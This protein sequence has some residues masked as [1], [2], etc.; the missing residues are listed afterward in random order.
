MELANDAV[1]DG[2]MCTKLKA[3]VPPV[4]A[5]QASTSTYKSRQKL[6]SLSAAQVLQDDIREA[7][8]TVQVWPS[9]SPYDV[10]NVFS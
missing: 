3:G 9:C 5:M 10:E 4:T 7:V 1:H 8:T 6:P 2:F